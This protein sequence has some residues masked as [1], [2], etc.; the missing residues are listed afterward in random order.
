[1]L[2][3]V[4]VVYCMQ[5]ETFNCITLESHGRFFFS[6]DSSEN[7]MTGIMFESSIDA[8]SVSRATTLCDNVLLHSSNNRHATSLFS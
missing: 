7:S 5:D 4:D 2:S 6:F 8:A 1:M 3:G